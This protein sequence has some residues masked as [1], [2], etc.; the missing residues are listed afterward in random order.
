MA[1]AACHKILIQGFC[2]VC[3]CR[4]CERR[5]AAFSGVCIQGELRNDQEFTLYVLDRMG[6]L[7]RRIR[8]NTQP[9]N[10]L[11]Q[12]LGLRFRIVSRYAQQDDEALPNLSDN[13]SS[14]LPREFSQGLSGKC[15]ID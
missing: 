13:V 10:F 6:E 15:C 5:A 12:I 7:S 11:A 2:F 14:G 8:E 3:S 4:G 1:L 9:Y